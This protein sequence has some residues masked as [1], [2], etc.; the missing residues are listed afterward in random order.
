MKMCVCFLFSLNLRS[1]ADN[2]PSTLVFI[3]A[4]QIMFLL[5]INIHVLLLFKLFKHADGVD[6]RAVPE[7]IEIFS[8]S[9][10]LSMIFFRLINV[11]M[12]TNVGILTFMS[13]KN[14][15]IGISEPEKKL[16]FLIFLYLL[17]FK[18]HAQ[19]S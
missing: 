14:S 8:C 19:L 12:P 11:K 13:R 15:I 16:N 1:V 18:F 2:L 4:I 17:A 7:V 10:Q 9:T 5:E 3:F 6:S